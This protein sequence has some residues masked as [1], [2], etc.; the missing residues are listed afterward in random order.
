MKQQPIGRESNSDEACAW[1]S[2]NLATAPR[3]YTNYQHSGTVLPKGPLKLLQTCFTSVEDSFFLYTCTLNVKC[4]YYSINKYNSYYFHCFFIL[5]YKSY[6]LSH[7]CWKVC[8]WDNTTDVSRVYHC[9][10][11]TLKFYVKSCKNR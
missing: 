8:Y 1:E 9:N 10:G 11:V 3:Q 4:P 5:S 2:R 6:N 7:D